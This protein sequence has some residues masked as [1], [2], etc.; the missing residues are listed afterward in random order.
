MVEPEH[1]S[2]EPARGHQVVPSDA[3]GFTHLGAVGGFRSR[4]LTRALRNGE[5]WRGEMAEF[6][7]L[8]PPS[9]VTPESPRERTAPGPTKR[10]TVF[11]LLQNVRVF[12]RLW[13]PVASWVP[14]RKSTRL[15][16]SHSCASRMPS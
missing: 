13:A 4:A 3:M 10:P 14:D 2:G 11:T 8:R 12:R 1:L 9:F 7:S 16:S 5:D 15:N 6:L